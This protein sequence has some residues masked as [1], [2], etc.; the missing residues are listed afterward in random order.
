MAIL[1]EALTRDSS[2]N[3]ISGSLQSTRSS[4]SSAENSVNRISLIISN[5]TKVRSE[6]FF[7]SKLIEDRRREAT[8]RKE[9]EDQ[10]EASKVSTNINSGLN[11]SS[12]TGKGPLGRIL[13]F[14]GYMGAGWILEN[15]PTWIAMGREFIARMKKAGELIYSIPQTIWR[16]LQNFNSLLGSIKQN[17]LNLD[18]TDS[19]G[20]VRDSFKELTDSMQLLGDQIYGGFASLLQPSGEVDIPSTGEQQPDSEPASPGS[21]PS[22]GGSNPTDLRSGASLLVQK[23]FPAKGAAYLAGNIQQESGWKAQRKPWVLKDEG[24]ANKGLISWNRTRITDAEKFLGKPLETATASEQIDWIKEEMRQYGVLKTFMNPNATDQQLKDASYKYIKWGDVGARWKYSEVAYDHLQ[25]Q[26][27]QPPKP[28]VTPQTPAAPPPPKPRSGNKN[29]YLTSADLMKVKP[30]SYPADYQDW[31]GNNA[32]LNPNAGKAFLA[33]QK[34]YGKDIPINSAYR[35]YEHQKNV[36]GA[37]KASPGYSKH[38]LGLAIDLE[39]NTPYH[40]WMK[41]NGPKFGWY[42]ANI[43]DDPFHFEYRGQIQSSPTTPKNI[44]TQTQ[45]TPITPLMGEVQTEQLSQGELD[46]QENLIKEIQFLINEESGQ[47]QI[48]SSNTIRSDQLAKTIIPDRKRQEILFIDDRS[49]Q[50]SNNMG[51]PSSILSSGE[52]GTTQNDTSNMLNRYIKQKL[53]LD[54]NYV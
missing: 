39:P 2:I 19:Y 12:S 14:L 54:L 31:Y 7:K 18:F 47:P 26:K 30:L 45:Q 10:I 36:S 53:L 44:S 43:P 40:D 46:L 49:S 33:A 51:R 42:Y 3:T 48:S 24:F 29:G 15:L 13:S 28:T 52:T 32:M 37:V 23:G 8:K 16:T 11:V 5:K 25:K 20:E 50:T 22:G 38:G 27:S 41:K 6:L 17:I 4:L 1:A 34:E 9:L 21:S 35:S